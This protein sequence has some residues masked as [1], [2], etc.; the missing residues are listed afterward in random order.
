M[1]DAAAVPASVPTATT[2]LPSQPH[3]FKRQVH[4]G[5]HWSTL[6]NRLAQ[7]TESGHTHQCKECGRLLKLPR[8]KASGSFLN[9]NALRHWSTVH[10]VSQPNKKRRRP[11]KTKRSATATGFR[12]NS[13]KSKA[14]KAARVACSAAQAAW[15]TNARMRVPKNALDD[16]HFKAMITAAIEFGRSGGLAD[17]PEAF[18]KAP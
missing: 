7:V 15:L 17:D 2:L 9:T 12:K 13:K 6:F 10:A 8:S 4:G 5:V 14:M 1:A 11:G 18:F 16:P 3:E